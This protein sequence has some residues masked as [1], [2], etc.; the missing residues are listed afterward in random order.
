MDRNVSFL[1]L[2]G[3]L[4]SVLTISSAQL[5]TKGLVAYWPLDQNTVDGKTVKDVIGENH[6]ELV[7]NGKIKAGKIGQ[8]FSG[9]GDDSVDIPGTKALAF[10][11]AKEMTIAA[12]I[13]AK[14]DEPV[15]GVVAGCCGTIVA[16]RDINGWALRFDGRNA[17]QEL[18]FIVCPGWNG[19][20]GF[21]FPIKKKI[22]P[23]QWHYL[24]AV[25]KGKDQLLYLD[26]GD[27]LKLQRPEGIQTNGGTETEIGKAGDGG[28]AG[29]I[30]EVTIYNRALSPKEIQQNFKAKG[31]SVDPMGKLATNWAWLKTG[32]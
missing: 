10:N 5:V 24:T 11:G 30:D 25:V 9:D 12:W 2:F 4:F 15:K 3:V 17:G 28:F 14:N 32:L 22:K 31:L 16:Q 20:G 1:A 13:N 19:D 23:G 6:G 8:A 7:G 29:L 27:E 18:E 26:G 21:G